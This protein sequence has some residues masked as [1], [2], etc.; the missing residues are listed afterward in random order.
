MFVVSWFV[1]TVVFVAI[2]GHNM[3]STLSTKIEW[4]IPKE[5]EVQPR[6]VALSMIIGVV[7]VLTPFQRILRYL[8]TV[9]HELGHAFT[10][11]VLGGRPKN[12]TIS[13]DSSGLAT[14]F[15]PPGWGRFRASLVTLAGY[16]APAV[17]SIAAI[18]AVQAGHPRAWFMFSLATLAFSVVLLIRNLWGF[19][20]TLCLTIA[21]YLGGRNLD[22]AVIGAVVVVFAGFLAGMAVQNA[23]EQIHIIRSTSRSSCDAERVAEWWW[24]SPSVVG[25]LH[26]FLVASMSA[27]SCF[28]AV[29]PFVSS[30][31]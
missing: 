17:A 18:R 6:L 12:I 4:L 28:L 21:S 3:S 23:R 7:L 8:S 26:L 24:F 1:C 9:V 22:A 14:Y 13:V 25:W 16:P 27:Y 5:A 29:K 19:A 15:T 2:N 20:W 31:S 11:G 30:I 10:A